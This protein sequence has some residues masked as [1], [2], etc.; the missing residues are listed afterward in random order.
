MN[1]IRT[2]ENDFIFYWEHYTFSYFDIINFT[3]FYHYMKTILCRAEKITDIIYLIYHLHDNDIKYD[4]D[5]RIT[6][7][8]Y[9]DLIWCV[10]IY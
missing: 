4:L 8:R 10:L 7:S 5:D 9:T 2:N 6:T 3:N 1:E